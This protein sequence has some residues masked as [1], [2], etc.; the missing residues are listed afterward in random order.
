M[1]EQRKPNFFIVGAA[2]AGTTSLYHYLKQHPDVFMCPIKEPNYFAKDIDTSKFSKRFKK[3]I[4][5]VKKWIKNKGD[6]L[7]IAYVQDEGDYL[8]LFSKSKGKK[9]IGECSVSYLYSKT[10]AKDIYKFNPKSKIVIILREPAERAFS[11]YFMELREGA[12]K[13]SFDK[14]LKKDLKLETKDWGTSQLYLELG[15]YYEQVKRYLDIFPRNNVKIYLYDDLL[16]N[17]NLLFKDLCEFLGIKSYEFDSGNKHNRSLNPRF[18]NINK[19]LYRFGLR[20]II[21]SM[22]PKRLMP[23]AEKVFY[24]GKSKTEQDKKTIEHLRII[25]REDV[26]KLKNLIGMKK[27]SA[28]WNY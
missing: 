20:K 2:K 24:K 7:H 22:I 23:F 27:L 5:D 11:H 4:V 16:K 26:E 9:A 25:F 6:Y 28:V 8:K 18:K 15:L 1:K 3:D 13:L 19:F 14:E 12:T 10:A 17:K 21:Q